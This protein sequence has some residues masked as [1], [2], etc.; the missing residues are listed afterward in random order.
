ML[1]LQPKYKHNTDNTILE[2]FLGSIF[3]AKGS[4]EDCGLG[5]DY[6]VDHFSDTSLYAV[7]NSND[8]HEPEETGHNLQ[9]HS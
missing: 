8:T 7:G 2:P 4:L 5:C 3:G 6:K 9:K 1:P